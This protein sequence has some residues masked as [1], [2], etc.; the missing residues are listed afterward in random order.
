[1]ITDGRNGH[2]VSCNVTW[3]ITP[4]KTVCRKSDKR[5][6]LWML[7]NAGWQN[8]IIK[9]TWSHDRHKSAPTRLSV[10]TNNKISKIRK[11]WSIVKG[12]AQRTTTYMD[13]LYTRTSS[14]RLVASDILDTKLIWKQTR[15]SLQ[16][17]AS[18]PANY[19]ALPT[20]MESV[21]AWNKQ[22]IQSHLNDCG[23]MTR[24]DGQE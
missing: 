4:T 13:S 20:D 6:M 2:H 23:L 5:N 11:N 24:N 8:T 21:G 1:M 10:Q 18:V 14:L 12:I 3:S 17:I 19:L 16:L 7:R 15:L 22:H 9:V